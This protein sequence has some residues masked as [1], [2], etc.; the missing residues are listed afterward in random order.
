MQLQSPGLM[1]VHRFCARNSP[2][3][4]SSKPDFLNY[5]MRQKRDGG[6]RQKV[7]LHDKGKTAS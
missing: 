7:I 5:A 3:R 6:G 4:R 1:V 2:E